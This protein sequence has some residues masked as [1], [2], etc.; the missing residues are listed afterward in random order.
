NGTNAFRAT[1][2]ATG[3]V[4]LVDAS[5][6]QYF[7]N[8]NVTFSTSSSASG[9]ASEASYTHAVEASTSAGGVVMDTLNDMFDGY[10]AICV[11]PTNSTGPCRTGNPNFV[12]YNKNG[13]ATPECGN[14]QWT[15]NAQNI[16]GVSV[17]RKVFV[18]TND[19]YIR[20]MNIFT[21]TT[22]AP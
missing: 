3:S 6:L 10:G 18:P 13:H 5:G 9:A 20:W 21:N 22:A 15:Y 16:A 19:T 7:I 17:Q 2:E 11:S 4:A 1:T 12:I 8:T 14:R